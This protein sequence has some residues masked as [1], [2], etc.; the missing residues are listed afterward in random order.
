MTHDED[1]ATPGPERSSDD[2]DP[3]E[4]RA[5][6][7]RR[8]ASGWDFALIVATVAA[9][10][11]LGVQSFIGTLIAWWGER[12]DLAWQVTGQ[13]RFIEVMNTVAAPSVIA[14][15]VLLGLCIPRRVLARRSLLAATV[16]LVTVG[17]AVWLAT[18]EPARGL[19]AYLAAAA[20]FQAAVLVMTMTGIGSLAYLTQG[21]LVQ[22]GSAML[23]LGFVV[24]AL[25]V[26]ALQESP[27]MLPAFWLATALLV[28]GSAFSFYARPLT[29][30]G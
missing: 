3:S 9:L 12:N 20:L 11:A 10:A 5:A 7:E 19:A 15:V 18:G 23:H 14:I 26:V 4:G 24:F 2:V 16:G 28:V 6:P 29:T 25:V 30:R 8:A 13:A 21:R 1:G 22:V 17:A 27:W